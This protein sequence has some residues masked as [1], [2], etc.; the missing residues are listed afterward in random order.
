MKL[1]LKKYWAVLPLAIATPLWF[2]QKNRLKMMTI[3]LNSISAQ[4]VT[5]EIEQDLMKATLI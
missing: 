5:R 3:K 4:N 1:N 2:T